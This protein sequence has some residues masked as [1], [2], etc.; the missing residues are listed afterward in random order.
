MLIKSSSRR[1]E[2]RDEKHPSVTH[3]G[4]RGR[5]AFY[6]RIL[7]GGRRFFRLRFHLV[8]SQWP[9]SRD[10]NSERTIR[11][12]KGHSSCLYV[13]QI[14]HESRG[15]SW[16]Y[17]LPRGTRRG[18]PSVSVGIPRAIATDVNPR[19]TIE[20]LTI[21]RDHRRSFRCQEDIHELTIIDIEIIGRVNFE[22]NHS[23]LELMKDIIELHQREIK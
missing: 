21:Q 13:L 18:I 19:D 7:A 3:K 9:V 11:E 4:N 8:N 15:W 2:A 10:S 23:L 20:T 17:G 12:K 16:W 5:R 6:K 14:R 22:L 1:P